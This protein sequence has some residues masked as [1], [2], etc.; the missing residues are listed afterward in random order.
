MS[1][2]QLKQLTK[3]YSKTDTPA[4]DKI[5]LEIE[6][7]E[8]ITLLGP[9][10]CGK[11]TTLRMIA[12]FE[13]PTNGSI[14]IDS[15]EVFSNRTYLPPEKRGIGMVFQDY[16]L[17]PHL[18]IEKNVTFGLTKW[19]NRDKKDRAKEVLEL[20]GLAEYGKRYPNELSGGQQQRVALARA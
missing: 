20:V 14:I 11:T 19:S 17:F 16:A 15:N 18:T 8:I 4:V 9:S 6:K 5:D 1:F 10:G 13:Q 7:G 12:G 2:I 3:L